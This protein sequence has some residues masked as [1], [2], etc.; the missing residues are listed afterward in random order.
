MAYPTNDSMYKRRSIRSFKKDPISDDDLNFILSSG[1]SA[2][3]GENLRPLEM[4]V[5]K[6]DETKKKIKSFYEWAGFCTQSPVSVLVCYDA[7]K[8]FAAG[9]D[10]DDLGKLDAAAGI[11]NMLLRATE[12]G[13]ATCWTHALENADDYR[14]LLNIPKHIVP[15]ALV[16]MGYSDTPFVAKDQFDTKKIHNENW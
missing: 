3:S 5:I 4:I 6:K 10:N 9:Y 12:L 16:V 14:K 15:V 13:I 11:E 7:D 1:L 8:V 2:P